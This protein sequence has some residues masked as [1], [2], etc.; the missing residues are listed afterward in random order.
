MAHVVE[1]NG[2]WY[3]DPPLPLLV[4]ARV[5]VSVFALSLIALTG[6]VVRGCLSLMV[7]FFS[8]VSL[9]QRVLRVIFVASYVFGFALPLA[10]YL[11]FFANRFICKSLYGDASN[12][13]SPYGYMARTGSYWYYQCR[14]CNSLTGQSGI[15]RQARDTGLV[16]S[17]PVILQS[18]TPSLSGVLASAFFFLGKFR[19]CIVSFWDSTS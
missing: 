15:A 13:S 9:K 12:F 1:L 17:F 6:A 14:F 19:G 3:C 2:S 8:A 7:V 5:A 18:S 11:K 10:L 4:S 16:T